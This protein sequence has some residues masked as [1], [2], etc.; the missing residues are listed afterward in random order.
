MANERW[1]ADVKA[2]LARLGQTL[3]PDAKL[4]HRDR[5][6]G[7]AQVIVLERVRKD[8]TPEYCTHGYASCVHCDH[9]CWLGSETAKLVS[10]GEASPLCLECANKFIPV[11]MVDGGQYVT[12]VEDHLREDGPHEDS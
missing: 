6:T 9:L 12:R 7:G 4:E 2:E 1:I 5:P 11:A 8:E 10:A 3:T